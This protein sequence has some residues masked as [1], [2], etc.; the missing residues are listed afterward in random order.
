[1]KVCSIFVAALTDTRVQMCLS[2]CFN[3]Y[4]DH[5]DKGHLKLLERYAK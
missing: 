4:S 1:M 5:L 2:E 3:A